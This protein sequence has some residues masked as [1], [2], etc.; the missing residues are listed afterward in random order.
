MR[1]EPGTLERVDRA[2]CAEVNDAGKAL[3]RTGWIERLILRELAAVE[4]SVPH[5]SAVFPTQISAVRPPGPSRP[6]PGRVPGRPQIRT[7]LRKFYTDW[8]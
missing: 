4:G 5:S 6:D 2:C 7:G 1:L 3:S 8:P